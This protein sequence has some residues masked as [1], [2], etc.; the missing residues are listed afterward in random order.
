[1]VGA[2]HRRQL[3][4]PAVL[5]L[6]APV[7]V[8]A[9]GVELAVELREHAVGIGVGGFERLHG[10]GVCVGAGGGEGG[11]VAGVGVGI[12]RTQRAGGGGVELAP[13]D[14]VAGGHAVGDIRD[15]GA[16]AAAE[17]DGGV[18]GVVV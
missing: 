10:H 8:G 1:G 14:R 7:D 5:L 16:V 6:Q 17:G 11:R 2:A 18:V 4:D 9:E 12:G 3:V 15:H 13:V